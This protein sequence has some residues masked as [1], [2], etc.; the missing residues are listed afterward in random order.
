LISDWIQCGL[1][2]IVVVDNCEISLHDLLREE[3]KRSD[4]KISILTLDLAIERA[5]QTEI[6]LL[7]QLPDDKIKQILEPVYSNVIRDLDR[8]VAYAQGFPQM[9]VLLAN[10]RLDKEPDMGRLTDDEMAKKL[11]WAG[12]KP[13]T[14]DEK[15][16]KGC[17]LFDRFGLDDE[18]SEE[19]QFIATFVV[20]VD[21]DKFYDCVKRFEEKGLIDRRGRFASL[22]PKPL[23][24]RL[25]AE[26]WARARPEKRL[27][28]ITAEMPGNLVDSFCDQISRLDF[29]P[30]VKSFTA[31]LCGP[32]GPF[33]QAK[34]I[35]S[36]RGSHLFRAL[37]EVNPDATSKALLHVLEKQNE[38]ELLKITGDVRRN[39]VWALEKLCFHESCFEESAKSLM[40]LASAENESWSNNATGG[41]RQLF[42]TFLSGT[43][44]P[45]HMRISL[46]DYALTSDRVSIRELAVVALE[47]AI[48]TDRGTRM[49]GAEYQG[50]GEPLEEWRPKVWREAFEYWEQAL[51]RLST[52]VL[53]KDPLAHH[54]KVSISNQI[55]GLLQYGRVNILDTL[56]RAIVDQDGPLWL[57]ALENIKMSLRYDGK[58]MPEEVIGK[59]QD[60]VFLLTPSELGDRLDL[61]VSKPPYEHEEKEDGS[62]EDVAAKNAKLLAGELAA[63][64]DSIIP[65]ADNLLVGEQ[66]QA[67]WFGKNLVESSRKWEPLLSEVIK[68]IVSLKTPN[69]NLLLGILSGIFNLNVSEWNT[70]VKKI[71]NEEKLYPYYAQALVTG[72]VTAEQLNCFTELI[73]QKKI[74]PSMA[75]TFVYGKALDHLDQKDVTQ[76]VKN[77]ASVSNDAAWIALDILS[78]Y[79]HG[80]KEKWKN[81]NS[82]F[83]DIVI[84]IELGSADNIKGQLAMQHWYDVVEALLQDDDIDLAIDLT[85]KIIR[86]YTDNINYGE[87]WHYIQPI[88]RIVLQ[89]HAKDV[90]PLF[91]EAIDNSTPLEEYGLIQLL[92]TGSSFGN[93]MPSVLADLPEDILKE[94]CFQSP[95]TA[96][97]FVAQ[98]TD[99]FLED[100][101]KY[102]LSPRADF[103]LNNFGDNNKVLSALW[104]NLSSYGWSGSLVPYLKKEFAAL[105]GLKEHKSKHVRKWVNESLEYLTKRIER[106]TQ[107]DEEDHWGIH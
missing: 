104:A 96:P 9:A 75:N 30:E 29:L 64:M 32:Q 6:I 31:E 65:F 93:K 88:T 55:R 17:A 69:I 62:Y 70:I 21:L 34:V 39:L 16:L 11:L 24:I 3:V 95:D 97:I 66:R 90:W 71:Y 45:P 61:L 82:T 22:V 91:S 87:M 7:K 67:R 37:V 19:Y 23:A 100:D 41:F 106:E 46:I 51:D 33:G 63:D 35:L 4:S 53:S 86:G 8:I 60:W 79:C 52:L 44:A 2:T 27:E 101:G 28:L 99:V 107:R 42:Q 48:T 103:L 5:S 36:E 102:Q 25:A 92:A 47:Q 76:F 78:M 1:E 56:I 83:R 26:W 85:K 10:A 14:E 81:F 50:S 94:W 105:E 59:L 84:D 77:L 40:L 13:S 54:A 58:K 74:E 98:T 18:V 43:E 73:S 89:K 57:A 20:N 38:E 12:Q 15:I 80:D 72:N 49:I 68:K